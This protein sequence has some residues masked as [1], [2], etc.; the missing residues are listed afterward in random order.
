MGCEQFV[1]IKPFRLLALAKCK[2]LLLLFNNFKSIVIE[3]SITMGNE[4]N[5]YIPISY[6]NTF[7]KLF[8]ALLS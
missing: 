7:S 8:L 1:F 2:L 5:F 6:T 3:S 4:F